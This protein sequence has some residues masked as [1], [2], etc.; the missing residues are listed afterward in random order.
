FSPVGDQLATGARDRTTK[1]RAIGKDPASEPL[2]LTTGDLG[3]Y[4]VDFS[5]QGNYLATAGFA[6]Q[7][8][9]GLKVWDVKAGRRRPGFRGLVWA[10]TAAV[11]SPDGRRIATGGYHDAATIWEVA[12][13][14]AA[15]TL[16]GHGEA[17][18]ALNWS[19]G[20]RRVA[21]ASVDGTIR[22]WD[23]RTGKEALRLGESATSLTFTRDGR[24]LLTVVNRGDVTAWDT[25]TSE[26]R[27][28]L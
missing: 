2:V 24:R 16:P 28:L 15:L 6:R 19:P 9:G 27:V 14:E 26:R 4:N 7:G 17:V 8:E 20:G 25:T 10:I 21:T 1:V 18:M 5:P 22:V 11:F 23:V 12:S 3:V 13:G